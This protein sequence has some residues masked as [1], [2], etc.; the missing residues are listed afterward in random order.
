[1]KSLTIKKL[2]QLHSWVGIITG[3]LLFIVAFTGALAVFSKPY[4]SIWAASS[5]QH[6]A[7]HVPAAKV[8]QLINQYAE[9]VP[10]EFRENIHVYMP[11]GYGYTRLVLL[12]ESHEGDVNY[13]KETAY[14]YEFNSQTLALVNQYYGLASEYYQNRQSDIGQFIA[15]FHADL[16]LGRPIGLILTGFL[17]LTL[18]VSVITGLY[19]HRDMFKQLFTFRRNKSIDIVAGDSHKLFGIWGSIF[20]FVIGFTGAFLGLATV[21]LL[22]AAAYVSFNGDQEKLIE[23]F[24]AMPEP[25]ISEQHQP[26]RIADVINHTTQLDAKAE[27]LDLTIMAFNDQNAVVYARMLGGENF[28]PQI[29]EYKGDGTL[30][31][32]MS[33]FGDI[34][35]PAIKVLEWVFPL[36]F[37]SFGGIFVKTIWALLG[38]TTALIPLSGVMM[39]LAKRSRGQNPSLSATSYQRWNRFVIGTCGGIVLACFALFPAQIVLNQLVIDATQNSFFGPIFFG[40]WLFWL[41]VCVFPVSYQRLLKANILL[42]AL[43]LSSVIPLKA[44]LQPGYLAQLLNANYLIVSVVDIVCFILACLA[45]YWFKKLSL[46]VTSDTSAYTVTQGGSL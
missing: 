37:G 1:M 44:V 17:G 34:P 28:A 19:I 21:I 24:T 27:L 5:E 41:V 38:L 43:C 4:L 35:G 26:T 31:K 16:H 11:E 30:A 32:S 39:W 13:D 36:H 15:H 3:I 22:P 25:V 20:H 9:K 12:Y 40:G 46:P 10:Q 42:V 7:S 18:M 45:L 33:S 14:V 2:F 6:V 8:E 23:T 29:L